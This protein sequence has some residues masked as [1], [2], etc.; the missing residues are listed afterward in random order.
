MSQSLLILLNLFVALHTIT[1]YVSGP[2]G[3]DETL[4]PVLWWFWSYLVG[5]FL[6]MV[7][8][9]LLFSALATDL[10]CPSS[11]N[12]SS[13]VFN[14]YIKPLGEIIQVWRVQDHQYADDTLLY[15]LFPSNFNEVVQIL[16]PNPTLLMGVVRANKLNF[17]LQKKEVPP[18]IIWMHFSI[19]PGTCKTSFEP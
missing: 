10:W 8:G 12:L 6:K 14:F 3:C 2:D 16:S 7:L 15:I 13:M 5:Q 18:V 1:C 4:E 11:F 19:Q 17:N 9:Q